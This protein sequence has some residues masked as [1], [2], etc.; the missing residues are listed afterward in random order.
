[1]A[2]SVSAPATTQ[3]AIITVKSIRLNDSN[4][5]DYL[6]SLAD[7]QTQLEYSDLVNY[8]RR[9]RN[10]SPPPAV[11]ASQ[12]CVMCG[13]LDARET[14]P[15]QNKDVC[16]SCDSC[17]WFNKQHNVAFKFCKGCKKFFPLNEFYEKPTA[18]KCC[19]CRERSRKKYISK[20]S[21]QQLSLSSS[22]TQSEDGDGKPHRERDQKEVSTK[23]VAPSTLAAQHQWY[24]VTPSIAPPQQEFEA[25]V[26]NA[27]DLSQWLTRRQCT[28]TAT[29]THAPSSSSS[30]SSCNNGSNN[31]SSSAA[32]RLPL[33][34][35]SLE[36]LHPAASP[37]VAALT[38]LKRKR[39]RKCS[40]SDSTS[41]SV[42][43]Y[44]GNRVGINEDMQLFSPTVT[45]AGK[46]KNQQSQA[47][48]AAALQAHLQSEPTLPFV[49]PETEGMSTV[50]TRMEA[51]GVIVATRHISDVAAPLAAP[52]GN[53]LTPM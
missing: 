47:A 3:Q 50:G 8:D 48:A 52:N 36:A 13:N 39:E 14:I 27:D 15:S 5:R 32:M 18:S 9:G 23:E 37:A 4:Y 28:V 25:N 10:I 33:T 7:V 35:L 51:G 30:S 19:R 31:G 17:L 41:S 26:P 12:S 42:Y 34:S 49:S 43:S 22:F 44:Q 6:W 40:T 11:A 24:L 29:T 46:T 20:K 38:L 53:I 21:E 16:K 1:M 45:S 2:N